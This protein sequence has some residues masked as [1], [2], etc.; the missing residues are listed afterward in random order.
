MRDEAPAG[1]KPAARSSTY[2]GTNSSKMRA[3]ER[4]YPI[5][6]SLII[7]QISKVGFRKNLDVATGSVRPALR[8]QSFCARDLHSGR[9]SRIFLSIRNF[10]DGWD[11]LG[12]LRST[13]Y[14]TVSSKYCQCKLQK[15]HS[16]EFRDQG[17]PM[18]CCPKGYL[19]YVSGR[20]CP[21]PPRLTAC[22]PS[23]GT[24]SSR[25]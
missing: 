6:P 3:I 19:S 8:S 1:P 4:Q 24:P 15:S 9:Q 20:Q 22:M 13:G 5:A 14:S 16:I 17:I 10:W 7:K 23:A 21:A 2:G 11:C 25:R 18:P 12:F